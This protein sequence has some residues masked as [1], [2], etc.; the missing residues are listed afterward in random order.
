MELGRFAFN[1]FTSQLLLWLALRRLSGNFFLLYSAFRQSNLPGSV[2]ESKR[3]EEKLFSPLLRGKDYLLQDS[4]TLSLC[5]PKEGRG[6]HN[7]YFQ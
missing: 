7:E 6:T 3:V 1:H 2:T 4:M 5:W